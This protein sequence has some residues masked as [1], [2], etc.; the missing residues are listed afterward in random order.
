MS[1][2]KYVLFP[3][4]MIINTSKQATITLSQTINLAMMTATATTVHANISTVTT[5]A[6]SLSFEGIPNDTNFLVECRDGWMKYVYTQSHGVSRTKRDTF[7]YTP[8]KNYRLR[9]MNEVKHFVDL[10]AAN[11]NNKDLVYRKLKEQGMLQKK[12]I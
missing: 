6:L 5:C 8:Q 2:Y 9:S 4:Y 11:G 7:Y 1:K 10:C 3:R 12:V